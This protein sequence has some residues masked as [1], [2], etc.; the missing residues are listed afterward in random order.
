MTIH[1]NIAF[2]LELRRAQ[3]QIRQRV[4]ELLS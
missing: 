4:E 2:G 1:K 3:T